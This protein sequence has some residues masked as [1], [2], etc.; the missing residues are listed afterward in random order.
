MAVVARAVRG[1]YS[2]LS[3]DDLSGCKQINALF[4]YID[5]GLW[6]ICNGFDLS[7]YTRPITLAIQT[8]SSNGTITTTN[9]NQVIDLSSAG[10]Y[11]CTGI[12]IKADGT[13]V[14]VTFNSETVPHVIK[15]GSSLALNGVGLTSMTIASTGSQIT[16]DGILI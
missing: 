14:T 8:V 9:N 11:I 16:Y 1:E 2:C 12:T 10:K 5:T 7:P 4:Y 13:D 15:N 3:T 6:M